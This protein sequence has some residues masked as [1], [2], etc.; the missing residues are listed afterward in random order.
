MLILVYLGISYIFS[1][2]FLDVLFAEKREVNGIGILVGMLFFLSP[3]WMWA[4]PLWTLFEIINA[5]VHGK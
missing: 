1:P 5:R 2:F 4:L 3:L